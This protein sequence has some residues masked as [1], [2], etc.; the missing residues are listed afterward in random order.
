MV[1]GVECVEGRVGSA[2]VLHSGGEATDRGADVI[3]CP[4][5]CVA[6]SPAWSEHE[7]GVLLAEALPAGQLGGDERS[8][9]ASVR[10]LPVSVAS[11]EP[12]ASRP[13]Q[14]KSAASGVTMNIEIP[15]RALVSLEGAVDGDIVRAVLESLRG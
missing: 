8:A 10:L 14:S 11:D 4:I 13:E 12:G 6:G 15:G 1:D 7:P 3:I 2:T 5:G 9:E